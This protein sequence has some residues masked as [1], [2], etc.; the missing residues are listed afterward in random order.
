MYRMKSEGKNSGVHASPR[1]VCDEN[2]ERRKND[3]YVKSFLMKGGLYKAVTEDW[4]NRF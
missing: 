4:L 1:K 2:K 3:C